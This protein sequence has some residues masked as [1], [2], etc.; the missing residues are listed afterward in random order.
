MLQLLEEHI[1]KLSTYLSSAML[2]PLILTAF[3]D[4]ALTSPIAMVPYRNS[5]TAVVEQNPAL[6]CQ[7]AQILGALATVDEVDNKKSN[8][9]LSS[10][11]EH[12]NDVSKFLYLC[13]FFVFF[14]SF[15]SGGRKKVHQVS[16]VEAEFC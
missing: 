12:F 6:I 15:I 4:L 3:V 13:L 10:H 14:L 7:T 16:C 8:F 5:V 1:E 11:S 2:A 9:L